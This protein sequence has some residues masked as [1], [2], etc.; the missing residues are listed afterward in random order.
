MIIPKEEKEYKH[1]NK[2]LLYILILLMIITGSTNTIFNKIIQNLKGKG[3]LFQQHHWFI[4]FGMFVGELFSIFYY[5]FIIYRRKK[6]DTENENSS[7]EDEQKNEEKKA[8]K[9]PV[10]T[11]FIFSISALCDLLGSTLH[12]FGLTFLTSSIYQMLRGFELFFICLLSKVILKNEIYSHHYLGI[13]TLILGLSIVGINSIIIEEEDKNEAKGSIAGII[14]LFLGEFFNSIQYTIQEKFIK[15]YIIHPSQLVGF[16]GLWG[17][18]MYIILLIAFQNISCDNWK[19]ELREGICFYYR[20]NITYIENSNNKSYIED[21]KFALEQMWDNK[22]LLILYIF[23][24]VSIALYNLV[25]IKLTEL[26]TS[27]HR[28]VVDEARIVF[29]WLFFIFFKEV[30]GTQEEF[31]YL[32]LIGYIFIV[33]GT[34]IYNEILVI[35]FC[36]LD[37]NTIIKR[38]EREIKKEEEEE[39][40]QKLSILTSSSNSSQK[41]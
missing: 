41:K 2:T 21:S 13:V 26:V 8:K 34:I 35:P 29:I 3:E 17:I 20:E 6:E 1:F 11:N 12:T 25:G 33:I 22:K 4:T 10:P 39:E 28:V 38:E 7:E 27:T 9:I 18:I 16:E 40:S 24:V 19:S 31:H 32:Q 5:I 30:E 36:D 37:Y 23:F 15:K 14:L